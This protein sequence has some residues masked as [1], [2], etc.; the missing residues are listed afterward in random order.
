MGGAG[1]DGT[2][3]RSGF[4]RAATG[5]RVRCSEAYLV[6]PINGDFQLV[7][8]WPVGTGTK[9]NPPG[10]AD[11]RVYVGAADGHV[12]GF[13]ATSTVPITAPWRLPPSHRGRDD[14]L[15]VGDVHRHRGGDAHRPVDWA[16]QSIQRWRA[17]HGRR[18]VC[19]VAHH[20]EHGANPDGADHVR[21]DRGG[22][23]LR[24]TLTATTSAGS[25]G[26]ALSGTGQ[27]PGGLLEATPTSLKSR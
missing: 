19:D 13:G 26:V 25:I 12:L 10:I 20:P 14:Q 1:A 17:A 3:P 6:V 18:I 15:W 5:F 16:R 21:T 24:G 4:R 9:F 8:R 11:G 2:L 7:G 27:Q 23:R 22:V